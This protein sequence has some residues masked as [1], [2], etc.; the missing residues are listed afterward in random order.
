MAFDAFLKIEGIPGESTDDAHKDWIELKSFNHGVLQPV[1]RTAS[2]SGGATTERADFTAFN[3]TKE[4]DLASPKLFEASFTGKHIREITVEIRRAGGDQQKY[5]EIKME[6][7]LISYFNQGGSDASGFPVEE[8]NF[9][10]GKIKMTYIQQ[11]RGD[12]TPGG[13]VAAGWD[14]T[15]NKT[16]V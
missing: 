2:S 16:Y 8:V 11:K 1:S 10:P 13:N 4:I 3:I 9:A 6:Q 7:V 15:T 5:L 12:G 14:L